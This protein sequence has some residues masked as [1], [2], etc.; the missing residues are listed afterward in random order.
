[1]KL[2]LENLKGCSSNYDVKVFNNSQEI[3]KGVEAFF[4]NQAF[5]NMWITLGEYEEKGATAV[6]IK[7]K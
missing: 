6:N 5:E 2:E 4:S 3:E 1:M 7:F